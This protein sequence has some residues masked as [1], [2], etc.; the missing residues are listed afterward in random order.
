MAGSDW[1]VLVFSS[2]EPLVAPRRHR[3]VDVIRVGPSGRVLVE[4][5][6]EDMAFHFQDFQWTVLDGEHAS[7]IG[8]KYRDTDE[9]YA[10]DNNE[11]VYERL[12]Q[13]ALLVHTR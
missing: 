12:T 8:K 10:R 5:V 3:D 13:V 11:P 7:Y 9:G 6:C 2:A 4:G 1:D